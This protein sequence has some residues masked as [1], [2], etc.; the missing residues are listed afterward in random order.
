MG[1]I[2]KFNSASSFVDLESPVSVDGVPIIGSG[3]TIEN[4][5][6][7]SS[8]TFPSFVGLILPFAYDT[9]GSPPSGFFECD[10]SAVSR[11]TYSDL[12]SAIGTTWGVGDGSTTF[13]LPDLQ[14]AFLRG[15][16]SHGSSTMANSSAFVGQSVGSF[17]N[18]QFQGHKT[19]FYATSRE[20]INNGSK[21]THGDTEYGSLTVNPFIVS[22]GVNG[23]PR[24]G[25]ETRP[26]NAGVM[27]CIKY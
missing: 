25:D 6:L 10:G 1:Y 15:T 8:V 3:G 14:G 18:D 2:G 5:T 27:Y 17:E 16:G 19:Q 20:A 9:S 24:Q 22:D 11:T 23:T 4:A 12:F 13:N 7:G 26:F 21:V